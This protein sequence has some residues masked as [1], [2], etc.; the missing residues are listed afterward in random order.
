MSVG[1]CFLISHGELFDIVLR[2]V[3]DIYLQSFVICSC[4]FLILPMFHRH[5][6]EQILH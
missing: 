4:L 1:L 5:K 2:Y 6:G 3:S